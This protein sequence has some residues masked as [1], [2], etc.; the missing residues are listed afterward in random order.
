[1]AAI[2][3]LYRRGGTWWW[4]RKA[5]VCGIQVP[6][7]FS[8]STPDHRRARSI[9]LRLGVALEAVCMAY[10]ERGT[11]VDERTLKRV[12]TD[13]MRRQLERILSDQL[14]GG[15]AEDHRLANRLYGELWRLYSRQGVAAMYTADEDERLAA[16]GWSREDRLALADLWEHARHREATISMQ[17][18]DTYADRLDFE[19]TTT[20]LDRV[21]RVIYG[22]RAQACDEASRRVDTDGSPFR[23]DEWAKEALVVEDE[24]LPTASPVARAST[25]AA[26]APAPAEDAPPQAVQAPPIAEPDDP[27][28]KAIIEA[29]EDCIAAYT[30]AKA[31]S[32]STC[33]Q[34]RTAVRMFDFANGGG[35]FIEDI[36]QAH[37]RRLSELFDKLPNRWGVTK[38]ERERGLAASVERAATMDPEQVG[39]QH[40]SRTKHATWIQQ[41]LDHAAGDGDKGHRPVEKISFT[42]LRKGVG[43]KAK[44]RR[45]DK[46]AAWTKAELER[47]LSAPVW[48]GCR[49][50][51][52]R[53]VPGSE[54]YHDAWYWLPLMLVL[55]GGRSSELAGLPLRDVFENESIPY[56]RIEY[57]DLRALKNLQS[58]RSLPIHP[59]LIRLGFIDYV[60]AMRAAGH[61]LLFPEM[62][63]PGSTSFAST[64]YKAVFKRWREWAFPDG[65]SWRHQQKGMIKDKDVHSFRGT[66]ASLLK[67][68]VPD[69]VRIDILGHEGDNE[70]TRTYDEEAD[71]A[72]KLEA[73]SLLSPLTQHLAAAPMRLRPLR[74]QNF[75]GQRGR[76]RK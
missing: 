35:V 32:P 6:L 11:I 44:K 23:F 27:P 38:Q 66:A 33:R 29:A 3:N 69:S 25:P 57:S 31:W 21:R 37:V 20:N 62:Y 24:A 9:A 70:T 16:A 14:D 43:K 60:Q 67:G 10:G 53:W 65:T 36:T 39:I 54:I 7:A 15:R 34:V 51:D 49:S 71:M 30:R 48:T 17:Q 75:G 73:L 41:V 5:T 13:A 22:A 2:Q 1:V 47:L 68:R 42:Y 63:S 12:F 26:C 19:K 18:I 59:E 74:R 58:V 28:K 64:F 40:V 61:K 50:L 55:Y 72:S 4:R 52:R 46:R 76:P 45:R 56:F 8:L